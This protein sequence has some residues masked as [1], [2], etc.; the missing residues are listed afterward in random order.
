MVVEALARTDKEIAAGAAAKQSSARHLA[1]EPLNAAF[2]QSR[3]LI[4]LG[5]V[6]IIEQTRGLQVGRVEA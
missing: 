5:S 4:D 1:P 3:E 6:C 2:A